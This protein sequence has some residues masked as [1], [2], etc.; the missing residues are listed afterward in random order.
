MIKVKFLDDQSIDYKII[1]EELA[2]SGRIIQGAQR[3]QNA[4]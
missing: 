3:I 4:T 1:Q 2:D